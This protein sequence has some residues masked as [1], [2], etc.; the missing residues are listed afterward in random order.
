MGKKIVKL[1]FYARLDDS[2]RD[3]FL[4]WCKEK[5]YTII[6]VN[7]ECEYPKVYRIQDPTE[8]DGRR[9]ELVYI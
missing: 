5:D 8:P 2:L 1:V 6:E 7:S 9:A 3:E 4:A